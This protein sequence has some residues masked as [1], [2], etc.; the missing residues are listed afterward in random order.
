LSSRDFLAIAA[1]AARVREIPIAALLKVVVRI[2]NRSSSTQH[3]GQTMSRPQNAKRDRQVA[4][5][6]EP[7]A[8]QGRGVAAAD[9]MAYVAD[10]LL[11]LRD[12]ASADG[13]ATLAGLLALAHMEALSK[14]G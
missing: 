7:A 8:Y 5:P 3:A 11:E 1:A 13:H 2:N 14:T 6:S 9:R 10:L 12:M 4:P